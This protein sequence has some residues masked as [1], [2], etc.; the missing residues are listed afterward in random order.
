LHERA[1]D[2]LKPFSS[3]V[4]LVVEYDFDKKRYELNP[5]D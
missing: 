4:K 3:R 1:E 2:I 5:K